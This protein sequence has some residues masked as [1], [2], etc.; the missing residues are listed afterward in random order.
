M[1]RQWNDFNSQGRRNTLIAH[2]TFESITCPLQTRVCVHALTEFQRFPLEPFQAFLKCC[3]DLPHF[4]MPE[5]R[6]LPC[7]HMCSTG[8]RS[9]DPASQ[10]KGNPEVFESCWIWHYLVGKI[11]ARWR[12]MESK[13]NSHIVFSLPWRVKLTLCNATGLA[14][15]TSATK[16]FQAFLSKLWS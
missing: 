16:P 8:E 12:T 11:A 6:S 14:A 9:G 1:H 4:G 15:T 5:S 3:P 13:G 2:R 10:G 7:T